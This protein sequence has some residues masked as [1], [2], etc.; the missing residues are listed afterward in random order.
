MSSHV[1][2]LL[3][4]P[5]CRFCRK[6]LTDDQTDLCHRCRCDTPDFIR[7]KRNFQLVAQWTA[8]W[9]YKDDVRNSIRRF[10]FYDARGY[11]RFFAQEMAMKLQDA[12][13]EKGADLI[14]WVPIS[15]RRDMERGYNQAE[16]LAVALSEELGIPAVRCLRKLYHTK[17][18]SSFSSYAS[19]RANVF[20]AYEGV[21]SQRFSGKRVLLVDDVIT[22][23]STATECAKALM[24]SGAK[25]VY[26]AAIAAAVNEKTSR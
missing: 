1:T 26:F 10:K 23:G 20:N 11:A 24:L 19:R 17:P 16:L 22:T 5:K 7:S 12:P 2:K 21:E 25:S 18:Q 6:L 3:F 14:T 13:F 9:Y 4:P 15:V 8:V